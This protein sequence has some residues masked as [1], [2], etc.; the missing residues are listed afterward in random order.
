MAVLIQTMRVLMVS[1]LMILAAVTA[2]E[3]NCEDLAAMGLRIPYPIHQKWLPENTQVPSTAMLPEYNLRLFVSKDGC[4]DSVLFLNGDRKEVGESLLGAI[5]GLDFCP[6]LFEGDSIEFVLPAQLEIFKGPARTIV[7]LDLP[8]NPQLRKRDKKLILKAL[9]LNGFEYPYLKWMPG[10]YCAGKKEVPD[11]LVPFI[12]YK[13]TLDEAGLIHDI[14]TVTTNNLS[15]AVLISSVFLYS[16][17]QGGKINGDA[18]P[19]EFYVTVRNYHQTGNQATEWPPVGAYK[20][21]MLYNYLHLESLPYLDTNVVYP[22]P[23]NLNGD[24]FVYRDTIKTVDSVKGDVFINRSGRGIL[25]RLTGQTLP[26]IEQAIKNILAEL[27]FIPLQT[28][29][30][31]RLDFAGSMT[32][33]FDFSN[34]I[35]IRAD[36]I[37]EAAFGGPVKL[38][39]FN[40]LDTTE[41]GGR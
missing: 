37:P 8:E 22:I 36:W 25:T 3:D 32:F 11:S 16:G 23:K 38:P 31:R 14:D 15:C 4:V 9:T 12:I 28:M 29:G 40:T 41:G 5:Q 7:S 1:M 10:Y 27:D 20:A 6:A 26:G 2:A 19:S 33:Y 17:Y 21:G 18:V 13:I 24:Y 39:S 34:K 30:G 35:R